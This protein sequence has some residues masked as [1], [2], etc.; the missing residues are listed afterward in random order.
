MGEGAT[1]SGFDVR[2][3]FTGDLFLSSARYQN[4]AL[5][6]HQITLIGCGIRESNDGSVFL[7]KKE[8]GDNKFYQKSTQMLSQYNLITP[9]S[10]SMNESCLLCV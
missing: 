1:Y 5:L 10:Q 6:Y 2:G 7:L 3:V 4:V 9:Q 8:H